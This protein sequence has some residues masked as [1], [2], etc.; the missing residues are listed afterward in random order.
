MI[1]D[2]VILAAGQGTR[3]RST[4]PKVLHPVAGK[5]ML[6]HV[7]DCARTLSPRRI[8]VVVGH[9]AE[10]VRETLQADDINWVVQSQQL[11][12]GHA[13]A[14]ALPHVEGAEQILVLYGDVPLL[15]SETLQRLSA[16]AGPAA[17]GLLTVQMQDPTGYGRIVRGA[18]GAVQAIV[19]QKDASAEQLRICEGNTGI[20]ALP[21]AHAAAWLSSLSNTNAQGEYYLTDVVALAVAAQVPVEVAQAQDELE[22]LGA[23]N[24]QQLSVLERGYQQREA[25]RLMREGVTLADPA[26]LDVRGQ[27]QVGQDI[28]IDINVLLEGDVSI[29]DN[30]QIG[31][32][33]VIRDS[34]I[35]AGSVIKAYSHIDGAVIGEDC[36]VGPYARLRPGTHLQL[37]AKIG[38][39]VETKKA[40]I[41][42]GSKINHLSY[43]GDAELGRDVNIGAGTITC[44]YDGVNKFIT[45]IGDEVFVGSNTALVAPVSLGAGATTAAGSTITQDVVPGALAVGRARQRSIEGWKR[46]SKKV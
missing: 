37:G 24:R 40:N 30:V 15:H 8:H 43:V 25:Q 28:F 32:H 5:P 12:T 33:C 7:I 29:G 26:R 13:V 31:P 10:S 39:F 14:Q 41:G 46:P 35:A 45:R 42:P 21:G 34:Q 19:E 44:N 27:V 9:G 22:V 1:L 17:L 2:I 23:N 3:M 11:G 4:L 6:G 16:L 18:D 38:N 20:M 36:E